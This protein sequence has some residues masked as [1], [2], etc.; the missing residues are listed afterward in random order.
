MKPGIVTLF[1]LVLA[2]AGQGKQTFTGVITDDMCPARMTPPVF[3][4]PQH[5]CDRH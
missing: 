1:V 3:P 4:A 2:S 5:F